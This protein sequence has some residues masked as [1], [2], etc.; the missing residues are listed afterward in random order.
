MDWGT[1][2]A[3]TCVASCG[4]DGGYLEEFAYVQ[5]HSI[6]SHSKPPLAKKSV[7]EPEGVKRPME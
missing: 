5:P 7:D 2:I 4:E 1:I 6:S 3:F